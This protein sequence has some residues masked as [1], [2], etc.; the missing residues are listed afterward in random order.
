MHFA[1]TEFEEQVGKWA[2]KD[3]WEKQGVVECNPHHDLCNK[4]LLRAH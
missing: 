3:G 4:A 1:S 2:A